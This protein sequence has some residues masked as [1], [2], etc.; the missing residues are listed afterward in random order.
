MKKIKILFEGISQNPGGIENFVYNIYKNMDK[1]LYDVS[2]LVDGNVKI[3]YYDDYE[4]DGCNF[5]YTEN[6]KKSYFKYLKD[7]KEIYTKNQFDI[8]HINVM[9]FSLFERITYACKYS[10]AEVIV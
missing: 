3:A 2:F 9:S 10:N 6:R 1:D 7:L 4:K 8:I 5:F